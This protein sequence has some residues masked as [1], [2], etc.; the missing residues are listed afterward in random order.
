MRHK[1][2][3]QLSRPGQVVLVG[4]QRKIVG[5]GISLFIH[6]VAVYGIVYMSSVLSDFT[7][8]LRIDFSLYDPYEVTGVSE[9]TGKVGQKQESIPT[10]EQQ[11]MAPTQESLP[12]EL[13]EL[14][15]KRIVALV[16]KKKMLTE[17]SLSAMKEELVP[18][19][20]LEP[21][22]PLMKVFPEQVI[23]SVQSL[24]ADFDKSIDAVASDSGADQEMVKP[25]ASPEKQYL[26]EHFLYIKNCIQS[27]ISY[28]R[29][30]RKMGWQGRV[31]ISFIICSDGSVKDI[32]IIESSGFKVLDKN[33]VEVIQKVAPFPR[34]P[35]AAELIIPVIY[36]LS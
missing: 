2:A 21:P 27:N 14:I 1:T 23:S 4:Q 19:S 5:I 17:D 35:V 32:R 11:Q 26:K 3:S 34:P 22:R 6:A 20:V 15:P 8:P 24:D 29:M 33:A 31:L 18:E 36:K 25:F 28:P 30:A 10:R 12:D 16:T 9:L 13:E 7:P